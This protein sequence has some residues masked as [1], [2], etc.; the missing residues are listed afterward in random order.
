ML[1]SNIKI[2]SS[3]EEIDATIWEE[4]V[5]NHPNGNFFQSFI[6]FDFF[7]NLTGFKPL[8]FAAIEKDTLSGVLVA[9]IMKEPGLKGYFSRRCIVWGGPLCNDIFTCDLLVKELIKQAKKQ[10][11]YIEFRN[12]FDTLNLKNSFEENKITFVEWL[13]YIVKI[14]DVEANKKKLNDSK[15]RQVNK[16]LKSGAQIHL[17]ESS[18]EVKSLYMLF[19]ELY[20]DK[21]KK[22]LPSFSFFEKIYLSENVGKIFIVKHDN[23]VI[24]GAV[25]PIFK[26]RIYE[27]YVCGMDREI[28]N[29]YPS[30][31]ATWA[32][33]E[34][35][36]KNGLKYFDFMGAG[37]PDADYGVREFKSQFG[38]EIFE[39]GRYIRINNRLLYTIG[40]FG[41]K[42]LSIL[43]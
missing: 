15:R 32:P 1:M 9:V 3:Y 40:K 18:T 30:A 33:I 13:N 11:I 21:I 5:L 24:G 42:F 16:S 43:K 39:F 4:Y 28:K 29:V 41:L 37:N 26:D 38:G 6:A 19:Q 25:C 7:K 10:S 14:T 20:S 8:V 23:K 2:K 35:A 12:L 31:L 22:P 34:Y 27:W 17:A 36:A